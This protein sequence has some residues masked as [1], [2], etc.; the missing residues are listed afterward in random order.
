[1]ARAREAVQEQQLRRIDIS[2]FDTAPLYGHGLSEHRFGH[3]LRDKPR[4]EFVISTK[5]GRWL[6]PERSDRVD[7]CGVVLTIQN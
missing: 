2:L 5:V 3:L 1:V 4:S 6:R 7:R